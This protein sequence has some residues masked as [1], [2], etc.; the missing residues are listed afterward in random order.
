MKQLSRAFLRTF[1]KGPLSGALLVALFSLFLFFRRREKVALLGACFFVYCFLRKRN[2]SENKATSATLSGAGE[3]TMKKMRLL[4]RRWKKATK[5]ATCD[6]APE[7][8]L[9]QY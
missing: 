9:V 7:K 3:K 2:K 5:G 8:T 6:P 4:T 1:W